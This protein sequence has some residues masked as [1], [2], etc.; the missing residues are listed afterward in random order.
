MTAIRSVRRRFGG[1]IRQ[2]VLLG[3]GWLVLG[4]PAP[5]KSYRI[6][7]ATIEARLQGDGSLWVKE[8]RT[9]DFEGRFSFAYRTLP[10]AH[11]ES[12]EGIRVSEEGNAYR[13]AETDEAG[14]YRVTPGAEALEVRWFFRAESQ[15]TFDLEYRVKPVAQRHAD[16]AVLYYQF[17]GGDWD[18]AQRDVRVHVQAPRPVAPDSVRVWLHGPLW[19][20]V[21]IDPDGGLTAVCDRVPPHVALEIRALYPPAV[22][23]DVPLTAGTVRESVMAEEAR[24]ANEANRLRAEARERLAARA[25]RRSLGWRVLPLLGLAGIVGGYLLW[26]SR[27]TRP[28]L[29][30][31]SA[32][33]LVSAPP[34]E[35]PPALVG[36]LIHDRQVSGA[37]LTATIFDLA[38][39]GF[40][41]LQEGRAERR[42]LFGGTRT[43]PT[44]TLVLKRDALRANAASLLPHEAGLLEFIFDV[45][46]RGNDTIEMDAIKKQQS[47]MAR[48]FAT[49]SRQVK[50]E[51]RARDY[52]DAASVRAYHYGLAIGIGLL[53]LTIPAVLLFG[54]A[55]ASLAVAGVVVLGLSCL[56]PH[57]TLAGETEARRWKGLKRYLQNYGAPGVAPLDPRLNV[58]AFLVYGIVLGLGAKA[59]RTLVGRLAPADGSSFVP[60]YVAHEAGGGFDVGGVAE[61]FSSM[62]AVA[63]SS[64]SSA[65]GTGGGASGGGGGGAG[66]G[67]GGAG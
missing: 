59:Y 40:L 20:E 56:I 23:P 15:R 66:G 67:G 51:A 39:R 43:V 49:W 22:L 62:V 13:L 10:T 33:T 4:S 8:S 36:Y 52:F 63:T 6:P 18:I 24:W 61:A 25:A 9:Y 64:M 42:Q 16:A 37:D 29:P 53:A 31:S 60:W 55:G 1:R 58:D 44:Y 46:A 50:S 32:Q 38:R 5:A 12:Y 19:G 27:G 45:L 34:S 47:R 11:G 28:T 35:T 14:T 26:R 41:V 54:L 21:R 3:L 48:F 7:H 65:T 2:A 30:E 17:V 57:R